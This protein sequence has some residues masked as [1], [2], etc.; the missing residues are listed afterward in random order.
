MID[1]SES[2]RIE[3]A[4]NLIKPG[5]IL[6]LHSPLTSPPKV[7]YHLIL[8]SQKETVYFIFG[9]SLLRDYQKRRPELLNLNIEIEKGSEGAFPE[10]TYIDCARIY[11]ENI[12]ELAASLAED[13]SAHK[14]TLS[15]AGIEK[16]LKAVE[17][18]NKLLSKFQKNLFLALGA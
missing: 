13:F 16:I 7:K 17:N 9:N 11:S 5:S 8:T 1:F 12:Y 3:L 6:R 14:G 2:D 10:L 4:K 18:D 15:A